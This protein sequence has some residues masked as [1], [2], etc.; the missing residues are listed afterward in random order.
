MVR[1][2]ADCYENDLDDPHAEVVLPNGGPGFDWHSYALECFGSQWPETAST[3]LESIAEQA[4]I[5]DNNHGNAAAAMVRDIADCYENDLD[6]PHAEVVLP[7]GGPGFDW[8][9]YALECF[10]SQWP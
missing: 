2:I 9:S 8:H 10:G 6:D 5:D 7:N 3:W 4:E 1:D